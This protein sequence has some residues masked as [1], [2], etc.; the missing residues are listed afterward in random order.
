MHITRK[1]MNITRTDW[2]NKMAW[3]FS[4]G[5]SHIQSDGSF[6]GHSHSIKKNKSKLGFFITLFLRVELNIKSLPLIKEMQSFFNCGRVFIREDRNTCL[7]EITDLHSL[8]HIIIPHFI[9]YPLYGDKFHSFIKFIQI[10]GREFQVP[11]H[12]II[13]LP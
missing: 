12:S 7:F 9:N 2:N 13:S 3:I 10:S 1:T 8:W 6:G 11:S 5:H 4:G